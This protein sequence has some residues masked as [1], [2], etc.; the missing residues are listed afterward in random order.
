MSSEG[1]KLTKAIRD[2]FYARAIADPAVQ[3]V[4]ASCAFSDEFAGK[5]YWRSVDRLW[6]DDKRLNERNVFKAAK[7][8]AK[9][10][11]V[12]VS[13]AFGHW[14]KNDPFVRLTEAGRTLLNQNRK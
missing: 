7:R 6:L 3:G 11:L 8:A 5:P 10:G 13:Y 1:K 12:E 4:L 2:F 9:Y 14:R